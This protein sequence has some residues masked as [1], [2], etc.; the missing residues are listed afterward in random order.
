MADFKLGNFQPNSGGIREVFRGGGMQ[1]ALREAA[2]SMEGEANAIGH[3]HGPHGDLYRSGVDVLSGT[4][5]GYVTTNGY[6]GGVDQ[7]YHKTLDAVNH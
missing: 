4:A 1:A 3:L 5:V 2:S 6:L 7:F